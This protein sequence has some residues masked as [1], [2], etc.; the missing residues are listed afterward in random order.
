MEWARR[1]LYYD[2]KAFSS[3]AYYVEGYDLIAD[4]LN[5]DQFTIAHTIKGLSNNAYYPTFTTLKDDG[6]TPS[7]VFTY[8]LKNTQSSY[9]INHFFSCY[10]STG[11]GL[12]FGAAL[13]ISSNSYQDTVIA[14]ANSLTGALIWSK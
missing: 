10:E 2:P 7:T 1:V 6:I 12:Y 3:S 8:H 14:K 9:T 4:P 13:Y 5:T 11:N